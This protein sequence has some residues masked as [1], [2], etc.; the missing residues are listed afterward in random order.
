MKRIALASAVAIV[1]GCAADPHL[2]IKS[3]IPAYI[4][5]NGVIVCEKTPC[6]IVP[7]HYINRGIGGCHYGPAMQSILIAFPID[8]TKGFTQQK[9]IVVKCGDNNT[10]FFDMEAAMGIQFIPPAK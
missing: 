2:V 9:N 3:S 8:K 6:S 10:V 7:P 1:M 4:E 5:S